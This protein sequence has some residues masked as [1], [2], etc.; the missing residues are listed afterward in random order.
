MPKVKS[1]RKKQKV[2]Q[3]CKPVKVVVSVTHSDLQSEGDCDDTSSE[4]STKSFKDLTYQELH[5][6]QF[7]SFKKRFQDDF[8][9][10]HLL[11]KIINEAEADKIFNK[12]SLLI[13][14]N[15]KREEYSKLARKVVR[16]WASF[17]LVYPSKSVYFPPKVR[18]EREENKYEVYKEYMK[19]KANNNS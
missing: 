2:S 19:K 7:R 18:K 4:F 11:K 10:V 9:D 14:D 16:D 12:Q 15:K 17:Q 6:K 1:T 8:P 5:E 13:K 3:K